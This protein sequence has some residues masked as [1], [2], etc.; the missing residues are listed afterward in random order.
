MAKAKEAGNNNVNLAYLSIDVNFVLGIVQDN[1]L[2]ATNGS[3]HTLRRVPLF[4][5]WTNARVSFVLFVLQIFLHLYWFT[6]ESILYL[7]ILPLME[8][9]LLFVV[10]YSA[11]T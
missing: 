1:K 5:H 3:D 11:K 7:F 2:H 10:L 9:K 8:H 4:I 6:Y